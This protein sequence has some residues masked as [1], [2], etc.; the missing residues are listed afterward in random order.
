VSQFVGCYKLKTQMI[1][2]TQ[3]VIKLT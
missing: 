3:S 2:G 1:N